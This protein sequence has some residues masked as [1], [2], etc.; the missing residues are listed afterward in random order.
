MIYGKFNYLFVLKTTDAELRGLEHLDDAIFSNS[1][2]LFELTK[3]R[4]TSRNPIGSVDRRIA[5]IVDLVGRRE[6]FLDLTTHNDLMNVEIEE[7]FDE[8]DGF[9]RWRNFLTE[10]QMPGMIPVIQIVEPGDPAN[11]Q[12]EVSQLLEIYGRAALRIDIRNTSMEEIL[13]LVR[14][15]QEVIDGPHQVL[16]IIDAGFVPSRRE[17]DELPLIEE[18]IS[19]FREMFPIESAVV[20]SSSF[21]KS[22]LAPGY[23]ENEEGVFELSEVQLSTKLQDMMPDFNICHGDYASVHPIRYAGGGGWIPRVDVPLELECF[24]HRYRREHGGYI[25]AAQAVLEDDF[26]SSVDAWGDEEILRAAEGDPGGRSP[27]HWIA[28]RITLHVKRQFLRLE[29]E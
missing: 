17:D 16:F 20:A 27:M 26:Y 19:R 3:S 13:G 2:P 7:L 9:E 22:V 8:S 21:P 15:I 6:F 10:L 23:G 28:A 14:P 4:I 5:Q 12:I 1:I 11:V 29:Q 25:R 24:Y 18:L